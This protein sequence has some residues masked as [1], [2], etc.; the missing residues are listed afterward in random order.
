MP[1]RREPVWK[2]YLPTVSQLVNAHNYENKVGII[3]DP[4]PKNDEVR[5]FL[6]EHLRIHSDRSFRLIHVEDHNT[7]SVFIQ[8]PGTKTDYDF[9]VWSAKFVY[10]DL[11]DLRVPSHDDLAAQYTALKSSDSAFDEHLINA[12]IKLIHPNHRWGV[13][14]I[15]KNYFDV[16][17]EDLKA[18]ATAFL[19]TLKWIAL[20]EDANY[21]PSERK[22][23]S[24]Y[25]LAVYALL[26]SGFTLSEVRRVIRF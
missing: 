11:V 1:K 21:P 26:E 14:R 24:K 19:S 8:I 22:M 9:F 2:Q 23:G 17:K 20:Q 16:V 4:I 18:E 7:F 3:D 12:V 5:D 13:S 6:E 10:G 15:I 25:T